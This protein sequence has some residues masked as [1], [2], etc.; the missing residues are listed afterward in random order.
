MSLA[1]LI[2]VLVDSD[3]LLMLSWIIALA[4]AFALSFTDSRPGMKK[5][6]HK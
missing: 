5:A 3:S 1:S 6:R 4:A 2:S